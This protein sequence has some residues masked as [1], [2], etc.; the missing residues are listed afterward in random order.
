MVPVTFLAGMTLPL[1][2][3]LLMAH[4]AGERAIGTV[5]AL[6]TVGAIVGVLP[7]IHVLMPA[8]GVK[9]TILVGAALHLLLAI[10]GLQFARPW[11][12]ELPPGCLS[13][14][15]VLT[16]AWSRLR[17]DQTPTAW[18]PPCL[19]PGM[20]KLRRGGGHVIS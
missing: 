4:G 15:S 17:F 2:T 9:G 12:R 7:A 13:A 18:Y 6:N 3:R 16:I 1:I 11:S 5:Y 10:A 19:E 14:V 20:P 8:V